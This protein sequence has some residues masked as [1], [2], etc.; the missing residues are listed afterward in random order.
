MALM[1]RKIKM[2]G[3]AAGIATAFYSCPLAARDKGPAESGGL[4]VSLTVPERELLQAVQDVA[5]DGIIQG[6]Q[7]YNKDE[8]VAGAEVADSTTAFPKW[9]GTGQVLL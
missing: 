1:K 9:T 3:L 5:A 4:S 8:Y 7:E 2:L 6:S